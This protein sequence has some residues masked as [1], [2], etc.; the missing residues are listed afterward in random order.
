M[1]SSRFLKSSSYAVLSASI[2]SVA[3]NAGGFALI[4]KSDKEQNVSRDSNSKNVLLPSK[5]Q[6]PELDNVSSFDET[7]DKLEEENKKEG[8]RIW[9]LVVGMLVLLGLGYEAYYYIRWFKYG[10]E[11][12]RE[13]GF[14]EKV[15]MVIGLISYIDSIISY[16]RLQTSPSSR[17]IKD[18]VT[19][20]KEE[21]EHAKYTEY[22]D[23]KKI[24]S[25]NNLNYG[26][27]EQKVKGVGSKY[28][29]SFE[30]GVA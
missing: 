15:D 29:T 8:R 16:K 18:K 5:Q 25:L 27:I 30:F 24:F 26:D 20:E 11:K 21:N 4:E 28:S 17:V 9:I 23:L 3:K 2:V 12:F 1:F 13:L 19:R 7:K 10:T 22:F 6:N 14:F